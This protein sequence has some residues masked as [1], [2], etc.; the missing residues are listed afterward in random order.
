ME[1]MKKEGKSSRAVANSLGERRSEMQSMN[2]QA[3]LEHNGRA[4]V[5]SGEEGE[6][7]LSMAEDETAV[8]YQHIRIPTCQQGPREAF[9]S[10]RAIWGVDLRVPCP[11]QS[12]DRKGGE[13]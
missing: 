11:L 7:R 6:T 9:R 4:L 5:E 8:E 12:A 3:L 2:E 13:A 1:F 10:R